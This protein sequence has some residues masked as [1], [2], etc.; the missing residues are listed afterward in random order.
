M[1]LQRGLSTQARLGYWPE[2]RFFFPELSQPI[3]PHSPCTA[4]QHLALNLSRPASPR[5]VPALLH[6]E[7]S[8]FRPRPYALSHGAY[9]FWARVLESILGAAGSHHLTCPFR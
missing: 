6:E 4:A 7:A 1:R 2:R 9:A 5:Q 3:C 8:G